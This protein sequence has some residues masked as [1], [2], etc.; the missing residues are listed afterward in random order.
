M[1][2]TKSLHWDITKNCNLRCKHCYN[3]EKYFNEQ[4]DVYIENEMNL[5]QC[6]RTVEC[7]SSAGFGHIHFLGGEPLASPYIFDVIKRA[8]ELGMIITINSNACL[9][10]ADI[11]QKLIDLGVDQFAASLDGCTA[12]VNDSIRGNGTFEKVVSNMKQLNEQTKRYLSSLETVLVFTLTKKNLHELI[13]L[14][15]LA[16]EIGVNLITLTT[17]IESGQGQKNHDV[18][19][20]DFNTICDAIDLM[21]SKELTKHRIPLQ[22]DMRPRFCEYLSAVYNAPVIY[23]LKNSLCCA[24]EDV[25]YLEANGNVHP[26]LIFQLESGKL[27]LHN[28][29]YQKETININST[30]IENIKKSKYWDTFIHGKH[31]FRTEKIPTCG[32]CR[33]VDECQPCFLDYGEYNRPIMECEWTKRKEKLLFEKISETKIN[34]SDEVAFDDKNCVLTKAGE[35]ILILDTQISNDIWTLIKEENRP[36][37]IFELLMQEYEVDEDVLK[38]DIAA[39]LFTLNGNGIIEFCKENNSMTYKK[40]E[41]LVCEQIDDEIIV[42]DTDIEKFYEFDGVGSFLWSTM[43]DT[44]LENIAQQVC[45]EYDVEKETALADITTFFEDLLEKNLI[46]RTEDE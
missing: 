31:N 41:N 21:V 42:F 20:I 6:I 40:K 28:N 4:S 11:Q 32:G 17:F 26:C 18:F 1:S 12:L 25:W 39:F 38:Y 37:S 23:N 45:D 27:A 13:L 44:D 10:T 24:G 33:Y 19:Q 30:E 16:E 22:I 5:E 8:K 3:A 43:E 14:P 36:K 35:P 29:V 7:F 34:I 9:L 2:M 15:S 46:Y